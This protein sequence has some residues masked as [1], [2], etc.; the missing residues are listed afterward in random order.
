MYFALTEMKVEE[1]TVS[2]GRVKV[3]LMLNM[4]TDKFKFFF[5]RT[6]GGP[7]PMIWGNIGLGCMTSNHGLIYN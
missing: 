4:Q 3:T 5:S 2:M 7:R 1:C 6:T